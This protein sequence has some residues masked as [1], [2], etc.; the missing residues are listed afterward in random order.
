M[1]FQENT[2]RTP[3][4]VIEFLQMERS[5]DREKLLMN[6]IW[7][8]NENTRRSKYS[9]VWMLLLVKLSSFRQMGLYPN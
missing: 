8:N 7:K 6:W 4:D 9:S 2:R 3:E 1:P 5:C